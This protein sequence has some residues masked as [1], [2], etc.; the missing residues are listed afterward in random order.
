MPE[1]C[2]PL[3]AE[4]VHTVAL[5]SIGRVLGRELGREIASAR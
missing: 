3:I 5:G 4:R 1:A 2:P